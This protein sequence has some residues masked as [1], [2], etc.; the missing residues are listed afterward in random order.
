MTETPKLPPGTPAWVDLA[1]PDVAAS[2]A[3]YS[4]LFGWNANDLGPEAG[5]YHM[6]DLDGLNVAGIGP[7]MM[8]G[9]PPAWLSYVNVA[10]ADATVAK[11]TAA[12]G[13][14]FAGPIDVMEAGR[15]AVFADP[16]GAALGIWQ[17]VQHPGADLVNEPGS[18]V[19]N[20]LNTRDTEVAIP[21]YAEVFGWGSNTNPMG[22]LGAYTEWTMGDR[23]LGACCRC[24]P[25]CPTRCRP[26]GWSTS[27]S[28]TAIRR[29]PPPPTWG[30]PSCSLPWTFRPAGW[31]SSP[32]RWV[33]PSPCWRWPPTPS[34]RPPP[35]LRISRPPSDWAT[36]VPAPT[37]S[38]SAGDPPLTRNPL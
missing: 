2:V 5:N 36:I 12:G 28:A 8:P 38:R 20:E 17:P 10:D 22:E 19:W 25:R 7:I 21:F 16:T 29:R 34:R 26:S 9:Q 30:P 14:V 11:V 37:D 31:R 24:R 13:T 1:S 27:P 32:I 15:M 23:T 35:D 4:G 33:P 3:F 18:L 6:C